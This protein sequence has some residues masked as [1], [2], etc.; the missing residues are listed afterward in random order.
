MMWRIGEGVHESGY[1]QVQ[2]AMRYPA[3]Y[4]LWSFWYTGLVSKIYLKAEDNRFEYHSFM[5]NS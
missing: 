1:E 5:D 3:G 4:F 2:V